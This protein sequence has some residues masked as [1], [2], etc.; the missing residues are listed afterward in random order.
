MKTI[1]KK[2]LLKLAMTFMATFMFAAAM[3]QTYPTTILND[4]RAVDEVIQQT[5]GVPLTLYV[6][7]DPA[8]HPNYVNEIDAEGNSGNIGLN[9]TAQW[10]W[11]YGFSWNHLTDGGPDP[12]S[13]VKA[14]TTGQNYV[15]ISA[16]NLP[17]VGAT[18]TYWVKER[19]SSTG[20]EDNGAGQSKTILVTGEPDGTMD[21][22]NT[23]TAWEVNGDGDFVTCGTGVID[24]LNINFTEQGA[25]ADLYAYN[26]TATR[27]AYDANGVVISGQEN[28]A[29]FDM[30]IEATGDTFVASGTSPETPSMVYYNDGTTNFRTKYVFTLEE[31]ASHT[32]TLSHL[33]ADIANAFYP[34]STAQTVTYILNIPPAT[35]PI[36]HIP[37]NFSL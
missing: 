11:V 10:R 35:G 13:E 32:S 2:N 28:V 8:Y 26:L 3:G 33:R 4:Y 29:S 27:T 20:C 22:A 21:G 5:T 25:T 9:A 18:R 12:A 34:V 24:N 15:D 16:A 31:V 17:A 36:Y 37:N 7:P 14:W 1:N 19:V 30:S 23:G 6:A